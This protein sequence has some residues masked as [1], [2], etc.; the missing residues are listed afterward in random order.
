M[1]EL[2]RRC[3][4]RSPNSGYSEVTSRPDRDIKRILPS[5]RNVTVRT[6]SHLISNSQLG[7]EKGLS[8]SVANVTA[9][10]CGMVAD[11]APVKRA[12]A[13]GCPSPAALF[14]SLDFDKLRPLTTDSPCSSAFQ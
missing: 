6:P 10:S 1:A 7:L 11:A 14:A 8:S 12:G 2:A 5:S 3:L 13:G 9:T 4:G